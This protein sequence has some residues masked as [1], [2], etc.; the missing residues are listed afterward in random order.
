MI[1]DLDPNIFIKH[2]EYSI[3][4][5][6]DRE[7]EVP[8][9][10]IVSPPLEHPSP[11][12]AQRAGYKTVNLLYTVM[13]DD[14]RLVLSCLA[15]LWS[16]TLLGLFAAR[17]PVAGKVIVWTVSATVLIISLWKIFQYW[18]AKIDNDMYLFER[19][20]ILAI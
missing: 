11:I 14:W 2:G 9:P 20:V 19:N 12:Y 7:S 6:K 13:S 16:F 18:R 3:C 8:S 1:N 4:N 17:F 10:E 5:S 15:I